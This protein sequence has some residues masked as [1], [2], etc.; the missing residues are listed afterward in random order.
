MIFDSITVCLTITPVI[1]Q[2][3]LQFIGAAW[4][5]AVV[6]PDAVH[7]LRI[8]F[9]CDA[10]IRE[11]A[12]VIDCLCGGSSIFLPGIVSQVGDGDLAF[13]II[14]QHLAYLHIQARP[15]RNRDVRS[16]A[17]RQ[18]PAVAGTGNTPGQVNTTAFRI[19]IF[20]YQLFAC[21]IIVYLHNILESADVFVIL[22]L[23]AVVHF[24]HGP[25]LH[26][27]FVLL[28]GHAAEIDFANVRLVLAVA[29]LDQAVHIDIRCR[30][31]NIIPGDAPQP[32][33]GNIGKRFFQ[34]RLGLC[35]I[36]FFIVRIG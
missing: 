10:V 4:R 2:A 7:D 14:I 19:N 12:V 8:L 35:I 13:N 28:S 30:D 5:S 34:V 31:I 9:R 1:A 26:R 29:A 23:A 27:H 20:H 11:L 16:A 25:A 33:L 3:F 15:V 32:S 17:G 18:D 36:Q 24:I 21:R 6:E 22:N